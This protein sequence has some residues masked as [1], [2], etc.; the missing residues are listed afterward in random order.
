MIFEHWREKFAASRFVSL[1]QLPAPA[2]APDEELEQVQQ[3]L[4]QMRQDLEL[5][6][7]QAEKYLDLYTEAQGDL[8]RVKERAEKAR[9]EYIRQGQQSI[10]RELLP[11]FDGIWRA[12]QERPADLADHPW[13]TGMDLI[14]RQLVTALEKLGVFYAYGETGQQFNPQWYEAVA[15]EVRPDLAEG[16]ILR[17]HQQGY[18]L[19]K[20]MMRPARVTVSALRKP[21]AARAPS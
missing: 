17:V 2:Y 7:Q 16:T 15:V 1:L 11:V 13:V 8:T 12:S 9:A 19:G 4:E 20:R 3:E 21:V 5:A 18:I 6:Q 10:L 14:T